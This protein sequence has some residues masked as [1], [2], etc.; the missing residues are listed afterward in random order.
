MTKTPEVTEL[1]ARSQR[2]GAPTAGVTPRIPTPRQ[3]R[4]PAGPRPQQPEALLA[5]VRE[6][7]GLL[8]TTPLSAEGTL[9]ADVSVAQALW[10]HLE[11]PSLPRPHLPGDPPLRPADPALKTPTARRTA[12]SLGHQLHALR[13]ARGLTQQ[14]AGALIGWDQPQWARLEAGRVYP[15]LGTLN[16][17]ASRLGVRIV[18]T[19]D[20]AGLLVSVEPLPAAT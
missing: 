10:D 7:Y 4:K 20:A 11:D 15:T 1:P 13:T 3:P 8:A 12:I 19:P 18:L 17:L 6:A 16:L 5:A 14:Q 2:A 9:A